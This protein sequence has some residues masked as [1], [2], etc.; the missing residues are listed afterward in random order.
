MTLGSLAVVT[1]YVMY[2]ELD[3]KTTYSDTL[4]Q[5]VLWLSDFLQLEGLQARV[6]KEQIIPALTLENSLLFLTEAFKKL[7]TEEE[8]ADCWYLLFNN[9]INVAA[10]GISWLIANKADELKICNEKIIDEIVDRSLR[11]D[12]AFLV[13]G[14]GSQLKLLQQLRK[15]DDVMDLIQGQRELLLHR[16]IDRKQSSK[17]HNSNDLASLDTS[18]PKIMWKLINITTLSHKETGVFRIGGFNWKLAATLT[19]N[20]KFL[21]FSLQFEGLNEDEK[22]CCDEGI[23]SVYYIMRA[24][25]QML[26]ED[27]RLKHLN[28]EHKGEPL[29]LNGYEI[30]QETAID[31]KETEFVVYLSV[32]FIHSGVLTYLAKN[33][34][35]YRQSKKLLL[36]TVSEMEAVLKS[37]KQVQRD[38]FSTATMALYYC[39]NNHKITVFEI[40]SLL[41]LIDWGSFQAITIAELHAARQPLKR[42][43]VSDYLEKQKQSRTAATSS[44]PKSELLE[45]VTTNSKHL[46]TIPQ[47]DALALNTEERIPPEPE[48]NVKRKEIVK[49]VLSSHSES[50]DSNVSRS[51]IASLTQKGEAMKSFSNMTEDEPR[52]NPS[53]YQYVLARTLGSPS[54]EKKS[55]LN[56]TGAFGRISKDDSEITMSLENIEDLES[57]TERIIPL[58]NFNASIRN[59]QHSFVNTHSQISRQSLALSSP[60]LKK[61]TS[62]NL[63]SSNSPTRASGLNLKLT[64]STPPSA[65]EQKPI[66]TEDRS[67]RSRLNNFTIRS[68]F[69]ASASQSDPP[70]QKEQQ[71]AQ[72]SREE[73]H[74]QVQNQEDEVT[75]Q[76]TARHTVAHL[77]HNFPESLYPSKSASPNKTGKPPIRPGRLPLVGTL[78]FASIPGVTSAGTRRNEVRTE[79]DSSMREG[80]RAPS[81]LQSH[82]NSEGGLSQIPNSLSNTQEIFR[83][84]NSRSVSEDRVDIRSMPRAISSYS[85]LKMRPTYDLSSPLISH[86]SSLHTRSSVTPSPHNSLK[87]AG[88][89]F[90]LVLSFNRSHTETKSLLDAVVRLNVPL[91]I[92]AEAVSKKLNVERMSRKEQ[93]RGNLNIAKFLR[94]TAASTLK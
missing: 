89:A 42:V 86:I 7:K 4:L 69:G 50:K 57:G 91:S 24:N 22:D 52:K 23:V 12:K 43:E 31:L 93:L 77:P 19:Q 20:K 70:E 59:R 38:P 51:S 17:S 75:P 87:F 28:L 48:T 61:Q 82:R 9:A 32:E 21:G 15:K 73:G 34:E 41:N 29:I 10:K 88:K 94:G 27:I 80:R 81:F 14:A 26:H 72:Q 40:K 65:N 16:K 13:E 63:F 54:L 74:P 47:R 33:I 84:H 37:T 2:D 5:R 25:K 35:H 1:F 90:S 67:W 39:D 11:Y 71:Q 60:F 36:L 56:K 66:P 68:L 30:E 53:S 79:A 8:A 62:Q 3:D 58:T 92:K 64:N 83:R 45:D 78:E 18:H 46:M 85:P 55:Q 76:P 49:P 6:I 44:E